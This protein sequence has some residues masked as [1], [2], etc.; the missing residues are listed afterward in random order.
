MVQMISRFFALESHQHLRHTVWKNEKFS[1]TKN[2]FCQINTLVT[3]L[4]QT[5]KR[6]FHE[7]FA[8]NV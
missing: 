1:H 5:L 7:I 4:V 6:Y 8:K 2:M 3:Y